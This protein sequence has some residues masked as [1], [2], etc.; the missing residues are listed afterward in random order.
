M[1]RRSIMLAALFAPMAY[2]AEVLAQ[3]IP[4]PGGPPPPPPPGFRPPPPP[5][6]GFRPPPPP[7]PHYRHRRRYWNGHHWVYRYY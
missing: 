3:P 2:T 4:G 7:P 6:P 5:P 1:R